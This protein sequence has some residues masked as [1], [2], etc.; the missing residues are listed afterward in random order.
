MVWEAAI[1]SEKKQVK[2]FKL[3]KTFFFFVCDQ[4]LSKKIFLFKSKYSK[5]AWV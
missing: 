4:I 2:R 1:T 3:K 5:Y